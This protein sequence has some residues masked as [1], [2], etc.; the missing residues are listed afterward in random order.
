M[1]YLPVILLLFMI[2]VYLL[3]VFLRR[4]LAFLHFAIG[5]AGMFG[6]LFFLLEPYATAPLA[7]FVCYLTGLVGK[8]L[9][10]FEAFSSYGMLFIQN[11]NGPVSLYV[12][13]EC[14]GLVEIL[15]FISLV[16]FFDVYRWWQKLLISIGGSVWLV[17]CNVLR[18]S[19]ICNIIHWLGNE[20]Y[21]VAHTIVGRV[22]FYALSIILYFY[23]FTRR[24]IRTQIVGEF[25][26]D[27]KT[28]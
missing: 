22:V 16:T 12:D 8:R 14:A 19:I 3:T 20:A 4:K 1:R 24:Q 2:W 27:G 28:D 10:T 18:L 26:Y 23:V 17:A 7:R 11:E 15:V 5:C 25:R 9:G 21:Y 6:F 13:F